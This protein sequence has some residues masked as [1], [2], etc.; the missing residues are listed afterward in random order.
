[1]DPLKQKFIDKATAL[2][3]EM[4]ALLAEHG[5]TKVD[6]VTLSQI[7]GGARNIKMMVWEPSELDPIEGIRFR[8]FSIPELREKL[9]HGPTGKEPKPE[10]LFWLMLVGEIPTLDEVNWLTDQWRHRCNVPEHV[11]K[12]LDSLPVDAHPMA[13]FTVAIN[14]MQTESIFARR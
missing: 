14:A 9:P 13:Q 11:F 6:E 12:V 3:A 2:K 8:G 4:K 5:G 1:M 10:G 7:F